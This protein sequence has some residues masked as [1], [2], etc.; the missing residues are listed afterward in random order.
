MHRS[1]FIRQ[2]APRIVAPA[3]LTGVLLA[4]A[5]LPAPAGA[6]FE[7]QFD[8]TVHDATP[9]ASSDISFDFEFVSGDLAPATAVAYLPADWGVAAGAAL[10][11]GAELAFLRTNVSMGLI[12]SPCNQLLP[13]EFTLLNATLDNSDPI[14]FNE[15][16]AGGDPF[17]EDWAE[18]LDQN[19]LIQA[20]DQWPEF[21]DRVLPDTEEAP[22]RRLAGMAIIASTPVLLQFVVYPPGSFIHAGLPGDPAIGY[23]VVILLQ[24]Y[25]DPQAVPAPAVITDI[26]TPATGTVD[27]YGL[28]HDNPDTQ[29]NEGGVASLTNPGAGT[30]PFVIAT[31]SLRDADGDGIEN[32]LDTCP[33]NHNEGDPRIP[34]NG[35]HDSD[36]LDGACDPNDNPATAG[37]DSDQD[38]D[39]Y[40]N[41]QDNCPLVANGEEEPDNQADADLD[42]IGDACDP[43]PNIADSEGAST[44][45]CIEILVEVGDEGASASGDGDICP[46]PVTVADDAK[47]NVD[48]DDD[49]DTVDALGELRHSAGLSV[50]QQPGCPPIGSGQPVFG[51]IDCDGAIGPIDALLIL[52]FVA[53]LPVVVP[54]GCPLIGSIPA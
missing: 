43:N 38:D 8:I 31:T 4:L 51:D 52:R 2:H 9:G 25:G 22:V 34:N 47:G 12:N 46:A 15:E 17:T 27:I 18:D 23:P 20:V 29:A 35:D 41:R 54:P 1:S 50:V 37:T 26:C 16:A 24:D 19:G 49:I 36:G 11:F 44:L 5:A 39:G 28:T 33:L 32:D 10:P 40:V 7:P 6:S 21:I 14:D 30:Y 48:C 3:L 13:V 45:V 42:G 53:G